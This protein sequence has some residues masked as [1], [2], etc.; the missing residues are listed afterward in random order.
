MVHIWIFFIWYIYTNKYG[1]QTILFGKPAY[2][3]FYKLYDWNKKYIKATISTLTW[4]VKSCLIH[5]LKSQW[6][7]YAENMT[8]K[9]AVWCHDDYPW[10]K[11]CH[12]SR[13]SL[14]PQKVF[15]TIPLSTK[16]LKSHQI[17]FLLSLFFAALRKVAHKRMD[18]NWAAWWSHVPEINISN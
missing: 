12:L 2:I 18:K 13:A 11:L 5:L 4:N 7:N 8:K 9:A 10:C 15:L 6:P 14:Q 17:S 1:M 16:Y 3:L